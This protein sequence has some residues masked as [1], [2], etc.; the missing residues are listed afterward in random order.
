MG[1]S[2]AYNSSISSY[3]AAQETELRPACVIVAATSDDVATAV[4]TLTALHKGKN[5]L[6]PFAVRSGGHG[7]SGFSNINGGVVIDLSGLNAVSVSD[8]REVVRIGPGA[9]WGDVYGTLGPMNLTVPGGRH[10]G[11]GAGGL[12]LGGMFLVVL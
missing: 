11:V 7:K 1:E 6:C 9:T 12:P 10:A 8:D 3:W 2:A 4:R 5:R